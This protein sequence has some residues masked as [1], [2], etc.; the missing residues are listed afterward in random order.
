MKTV[1]GL[2]CNSSSICS[3]S[4]TSIC[5]KRK[6]ALRAVNKVAEL[7]TGT[8]GTAV[9]VMGTLF[10]LLIFLAF[11]LAGRNPEH[12]RT[13]IY[14]E[15]DNKV[16]QYLI[17]KFAISGVTG[18]G[19]WAI[20]WLF[21]FELA[22]LFGTLAFLLNFIPSVGS[23]IAT[24]LPLP[25]ALAQF[26]PQEQWWSVIGV[27]AVPGALQMLVGNVIEPRIMGRGLDLHPVTVILALAFWGLLWGV[28]GMMLAIPI[29]AVV[30]LMLD[31]Y[32]TTRGVAQ[33]LAGRLPEAPTQA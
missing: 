9:N 16:R 24:L 13:G 26:G 5:N 32:E 17:A 12:K 8:V 14:L 30:Q 31:R 23:V 22:V 18:I 33:M 2:W 25:L 19:V 29:T 27:V 20:L 11:L 3:R 10:L 21:G 7:V 15:V 6:T 1:C 4:T 28:I